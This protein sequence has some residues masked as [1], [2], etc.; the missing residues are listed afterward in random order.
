[1]KYVDQSIREK[2]QLWKLWKMGGSKED[3]LLAKKCDKRALYNAKKVTQ[4]T[5]FTQIN[6]E[7]DWNKIFKLAKKMKVEN[8]YFTGD[9]CVK[10]KDNFV[11]GDKKNYKSGKPTLN[12][13]YMWSRIRLNGS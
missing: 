5:R 11:L 8:T 4:E 6:T 12:S 13:C 7:K 3:Y 10:N 1:M 9:K 2:W